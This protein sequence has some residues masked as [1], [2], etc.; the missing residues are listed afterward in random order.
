MEKIEVAAEMSDKTASEAFGRSSGR[1][2]WPVDSRN[3]VAKFGKFKHPKFRTVVINRGI[4]I[5]ATYGLPV[6]SVFGG[7][8]KY[9]DWFEGY[10]KMVIIQHGGGYYTIYCHMSD[11]SVKEGDKVGIKQTIGAVGD[12]ESFFGNELYFEMR[13]KSEPVDPLL[14]LS[15]V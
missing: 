2:P 10:G 11:I 9:A 12:S 3:V 7:V 4:H 1:F 13:K 5:S 15:R 14:F 6:Y 8:V